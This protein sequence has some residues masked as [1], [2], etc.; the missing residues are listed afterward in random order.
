VL[1]V[2]DTLMALSLEGATFA[3]I[4]ERISAASLRV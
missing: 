1:P 4:I 2:P 3:E